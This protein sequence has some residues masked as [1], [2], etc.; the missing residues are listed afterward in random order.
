MFVSVNTVRTHVRSVLR[1]LG[2]SSR[3][4]AVRRAWRLGL[5]P[6]VNQNMTSAAGAGAKDR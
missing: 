3:N 2:A 6:N 4:Q 5:L 1:K